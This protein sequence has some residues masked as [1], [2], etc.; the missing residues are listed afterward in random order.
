[1]FRPLTD[2]RYFIQLFNATGRSWLAAMR[3]CRQLGWD[4]PVVETP[5][6]LAEIAKVLD[7]P[8]SEYYLGAEWDNALWAIKRHI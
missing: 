3:D 1:M 2:R 6:I 4:L 8:A 7:P 5:D